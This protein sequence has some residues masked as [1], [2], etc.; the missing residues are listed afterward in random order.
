MYINRNIKGT[1]V[2]WKLRD[3]CI[4]WLI[5]NRIASVTLS[6]FSETP[7]NS[8]LLHCTLHSCISKTSHQSLGFASFSNE[9]GCENRE[10]WWRRRTTRWKSITTPL[11]SFFAYLLYS[12]S[13]VN[14]MFFSFAF[15]F[16]RC[17]SSTLY[18][19][20]RENPKHRKKCRTWSW[21]RRRRRWELFMKLF[22]A[23]YHLIL[24]FLHFSICCLYI[25]IYIYITHNKHRVSS[26]KCCSV[27]FSVMV[28]NV[29]W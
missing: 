13:F 17:C 28:D 7:L 25:Y 1:L 4:R 10:T 22:K 9:E 11:N 5:K 27:K 2:H 15:S 24:P 20:S 18:L 3:A 8:R 29:K 23:Q 6:Q 26:K 19:F 12:Y 21:L 14:A 16:L